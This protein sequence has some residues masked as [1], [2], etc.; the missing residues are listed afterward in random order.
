[1]DQHGSVS[2]P[3][4]QKRQERLKM[5]VSSMSC[6]FLYLI[7]DHPSSRLT[8]VSADLRLL[9]SDIVIE[10]FVNSAEDAEKLSG[11]VDDIRD[12]ITEYQ[13]RL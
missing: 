2:D 3:S 9:L 1:M 5:S 4:Q 13:V 7:F 12:A 8:K 11:L 10:R 6:I